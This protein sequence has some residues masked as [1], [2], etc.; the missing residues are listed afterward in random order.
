MPLTPKGKKIMKAMRKQ[1]GKKEGESVFYASKNKGTIKGV[2]EDMDINEQSAKSKRKAERKKDIEKKLG[3]RANFPE[4]QAS[5]D[6]TPAPNPHG[7]SEHGPGEE[8]NKRK[9]R[10]EKK[11]KIKLATIVSR[12]QSRKGKNKRAKDIMKE[13]LKGEAHTV[14]HDM[15][16]LMAESLGLVSEASSKA[17]LVQRGKDAGAPST[18]FK[19]SVKNDDSVERARAAY[20]A[21]VARQS[22]NMIGA[23]EEPSEAKK[24][25]A[26]RKRGGTKERVE[27]AQGVRYRLGTR[28]PS[29]RGTTKVTV[30][31]STKKKVMK[32]P[33]P[34]KYK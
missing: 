30:K 19:R 15:G 4:G 6:V 20:K 13:R 11:K 26:A 17:D 5:D 32:T 9:V 25:R 12:T 7:T 3:P 31:P 34:P 22:Q 2:D 8:R 21:K 16:Y 24:S 14:Y 18:P 10:G 28:R 1:Y 27:A 33:K 29:R 23:D